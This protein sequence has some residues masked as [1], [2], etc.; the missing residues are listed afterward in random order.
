MFL[1]KK[2]NVMPGYTGHT[3]DQFDDDGSETF[4]EIRPQIPG[5]GGYI[6]AVKSE[7]LFGK[8][9][10]T[11]T[12]KSA[13][14]QFTRGIDAPAEE[15][16]KSIGMDEFKDQVTVNAA[17]AAKTVGVRKDDDTYKKP[18]DPDMVNKFWGIKDEEM[19]SLVQDQHLQRNKNA[20]YDHNPN[21]KTIRNKVTP[22]SE[23]DA[24]NNFFAVEE[25]Q[26]LKIGAPIPGYSGVNR[27]VGADN[28]FG[29]TYAEARRRAGESQNKITGE[30]GETLKMNSTFVPAYNRPH[31]DE[32]WME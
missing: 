19:D 30:K 1:E 15:K 29:M 6:P 18:L 14:K 2:T 13:A 17:T 3:Q 20:F 25:K 24:M 8:T 23:K 32:D 27:R 16:Y 31:D 9:Y 26:E 28:V 22:Q 7:N 12:Y 10:G 11:V 5:Y 4:H 21:E